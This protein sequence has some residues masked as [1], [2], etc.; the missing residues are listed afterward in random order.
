MSNRTNECPKVTD[1]GIM[2]LI[3]SFIWWVY[4]PLVLLVL[5]A[6]CSQPTFLQV[7]VLGIQA[8]LPKRQSYLRDNLNLMN[9]WP[10][11]RWGQIRGE[12]QVLELSWGTRAAGP[13]LS[14]RPRSVPSCAPS[15]FLTPL[16]RTARSKESL[17]KN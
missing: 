12:K 16:L 3:S 4:Q 15:P 9:G 14:P 7:I 5:V 2:L 11:S 8:T 10:V 1:T 13:Q 6:N 17:A